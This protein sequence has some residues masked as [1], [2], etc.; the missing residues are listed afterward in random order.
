MLCKALHEKFSFS[1]VF[2]FGDLNFRIDNVRNDDIRKK[3]KEDD[4]EILL[5]ND[6]VRIQ[7]IIIRYVVCDQVALSNPVSPTIVANYLSFC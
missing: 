3:A 5:K 1:Y 4:F 6:Q 2:W 7:C